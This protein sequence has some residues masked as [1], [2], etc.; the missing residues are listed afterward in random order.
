M[1]LGLCI[2]LAYDLDYAEGTV[3]EHVHLLRC[4]GLE[5]GGPPGAQPAQRFTRCAPFLHLYDSGY[6]HIKITSI[7]KKTR[8]G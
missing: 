5:E 6:L 2:L 8:I 3:E 4:Q 1:L 7:K